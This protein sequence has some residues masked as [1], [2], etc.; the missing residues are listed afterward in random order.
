MK[1]LL[2]SPLI[3]EC[4]YT[5]EYFARWPQLGIIYIASTLEKAHH[6]VN[7]I[8]RKLIAGDSYPCGNKIDIV[9]SVFL[10]AVK[11][12]NPDMIGITATTPVIM[13]A[14]HTAKIIKKSMPEIKIIIGGRHATSLPEST[15]TECQ[16]IDMVCIGEGE[17]TLL[18]LADGK[19][20]ESIEGIAYR[21]NGGDITRNPMRKLSKNIDEIPP[22]AWH[23][24][25]RDFYFRSTLSIMRGD[26]M[27]SATMFTA[28][29]CPYNCTF[30]QSPELLDIYNKNYI[31]FHSV[32]RVIDEIKYLV[33]IFGVNGISFSDDLFSLKRQRVFEICQRIIDEGLNKTIKFMVN[34]RA[35]RVD[36]EMLLILKEAGCIHV[37]YGCESGS[38]DTLRRMNKQLDLKKSVEAICLTKS[39]GLTCEANIVI[40][41]PGETPADFLKTINF[42]K[43]AR[44]DRI[45][46]SKFYPIPGT[47]FYKNLVERGIIKISQNWDEL[48]T[49]Y[50]ETDNFTFANMTA[51]KFLKLRN[52]ANREIVLWTN[53][54]Y[55]V[56]KNFNKDI[57]LAITQLIKMGIYISFY[58]LPLSVQVRIKKFADMINFNLRYSFRK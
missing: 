55:V 37:V 51:E 36:R 6:T 54:M 48:N 38:E 49:L 47:Q 43:K 29:G 13:D 56:R 25:N 41:T 1:V 33:N 27:R 44:P 34:M 5:G 39:I 12:F 17:L 50:V 35:D 19:P 20:I 57:K 2:V 46:V 30:C 9:D 52:K 31:R 45:F 58:Y 42:L 32:E 3:Q 40:G 4:N 18:D 8:E 23:L 53:Y 21:K 10:K 14:Y 11:D 24:L 16:Q 7:I 22:P 26:Y 28:R 15:L